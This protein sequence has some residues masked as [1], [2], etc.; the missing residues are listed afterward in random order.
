MAVITN[1]PDLN[2]PEIRK[3]FTK[4][5]RGGRKDYGGLNP[6]PSGKIELW[7]GSALNN[8]TAG[9][10]GLFA[11]AENNPDCKVGF[12][13]VGTYFQDAGSWYN[14]GNESKWDKYKRGKDPMSGA[15]ICYDNHVAYV[16]KIEGDK[17]T[18]LSS[19]YGNT[20]PDGFDWRVVYKS[21]NYKWPNSN[22][23]AWQGFIFPKGQEPIPPKPEPET[24]TTEQAIHKMAE[25]VIKG[26]YGNGEVRAQKL[27]N[28]I[29]KEV[30]RI[31]W[32][33]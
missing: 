1:K 27:Y 30:N 14:N 22:V 31:I 32:G 25:D 26:M 11:M 28:A 20:T 8:C 9:A 33:R 23:G 21:E 16:C 2:N 19:G 29:Q 15:I 13:K 12:I 3:W 5:G 18:L 4:N 24:I 7:E 10:W 6:G 17:L